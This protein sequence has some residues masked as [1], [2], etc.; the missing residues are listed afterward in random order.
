[1]LSNVLNALQPAGLLLAAAGIVSLA[2]SEP[3][4]K[5]DHFLAVLTPSVDPAASRKIVE[6][7]GAAM[8]FIGV[9]LL[10][11]DQLAK[12]L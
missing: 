3:L 4:A 2:F 5:L 7:F 8:G 9:V 1:M 11:A 10:F 6:I 12:R